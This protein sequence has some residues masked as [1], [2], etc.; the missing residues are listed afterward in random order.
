MIPFLVTLR[1]SVLGGCDMKYAKF[2]KG[3]LT[4]KARLEEACKI[5]MNERCSAVLL[6]K[7]PSKEK[8][9]GS[10][11]IPCD[12]GQL[13]INN[14]L[15]YLGA[16]ISLMPYTMYKK[17]GLGEPKATRMSLE[18]ADR[19][20]QYPRGIIENTINEEAQEL[21]ANEEPDSFLSRGLEKAIDQSDL[22]CCE[23]ASSNEKNGPDSENSI[24]RIDSANTPYP[25][26]QETT[27]VDDVKSE[28]LYSASA[29][30]IDEK[31]PELKF[32]PQHSEY[33]YLHGDK[34]FPIIISF[35]LSKK[36]KISLLQV[37][38]RQK[39]A[40]AW[41]MLDIKGISLSYCTHKIL[42]EDDYKLVIQPQRRLNPKVQDV[43]KN[44]IVKL[45]DSRLIYPISDSSWFLDGGCAEFDGK[46]D[47]VALTRWIEKIES[48][49]N[50]SGCTV[51]Q[52]VRYAACC[53]M[54][55]A[56]TWCNTQVQARGR[57]AAIGMSWNDFRTL[58]VEEFCPSNEIEKLKNEF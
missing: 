56:L 58:L 2:L 51:N 29:N 11:T 38:E 1:V 45:L 10:F 32:F 47:A 8:D 16:S 13:H 36:E 22:E 6:N 3:L 26:T 44:E 48:V 28:H 41:K 46:G 55:K 42:M 35:E 18:L 17:L 49:F 52:R 21:L 53:F 14:A 43:V 5:I 57:E 39:G 7:L 34:S 20:I 19:S 54:N 12:I 9:P 24:R 23:S 33:A 27:N 31:K 25:V 4:N 37:L 15:A 40:I 50:N 30:E